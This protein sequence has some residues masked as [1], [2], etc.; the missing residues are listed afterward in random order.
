[1]CELEQVYS[2]FGVFCSCFRG[3]LGFYWEA[4]KIDKKVIVG[5]DRLF[6]LDLES[7]MVEL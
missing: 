1:M 4:G 6:E 5:I 2:R 3:V 7:P